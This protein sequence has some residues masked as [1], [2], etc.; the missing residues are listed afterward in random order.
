MP[1][2]RQSIPAADRQGGIHTRAQLADRRDMCDWI[3]RR[4]PP[5]TIVLTPPDHQ[6]FKWY[7]ERSEVVTWKDVPQDAISIIEWSEPTGRIRCWQSCRSPSEA[8]AQLGQLRQAYGFDYVVVRWPREIAIDAHPVLYQNPHY[9]VLQ[10]IQD[11]SRYPV[12]PR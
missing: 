10:V 7:A 9:A 4:L 12:L 5:D 8:D 1:C 3:R 6:T 2:I 11:N